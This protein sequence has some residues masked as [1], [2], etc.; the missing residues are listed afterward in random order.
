MR[1]PRPSCRDRRANLRVLGREVQELEE[2]KPLSP[3]T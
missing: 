1:N 2:A 3:K